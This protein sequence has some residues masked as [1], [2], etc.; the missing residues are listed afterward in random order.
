MSRRR[1][2]RAADLVSLLVAFVASAVVIGLLGAGLFIPTVGAAG[3]LTRSSID[4]FDSLPNEFTRAPVSQRSTILDAK[5]NVIATPY[6][7]NRVVVPLAQ[8]APIMRKAQVA[9]EDSRFYKHGGVDVRGVLRALVANASS[10]SIQGGS[11]L[12]QQYV[13]LLLEETALKSGDQAAAQAATARSGVTGVTRKLQE[14][15]F[16]IQ[17]EKTMTKD[18][19]LQGYLNLVYYGD[20][21]Y[22]VEAAASHYFNKS[23]KDLNL[24]EAAMIAGLSQNPG[25]SDPVHDPDKALARCNV[26]LERMGQLGLISEKD[27][28]TAQ[29]VPLEQMMHVTTTPNSCSASGDNATSA[30]TS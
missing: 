9:I 24:P 7:V 13:K 14:L 1:Q 23:A 4:V 16:S 25:T 8:V 10:T 29:A 12:T 18:Q 3:A 15:K 22:G 27:L 5:G 6:H 17:L 2:S 20:Q 19:I 30:T 11:T 21:A 26:V 28:A